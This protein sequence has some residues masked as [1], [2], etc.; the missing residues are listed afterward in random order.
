M[1]TTIADIAKKVGVTGATVSLVLNKNSRISPKTAERVL[2]AA[3]ELEYKPSASARALARRKTENIG[4]LHYTTLQSLSANP[5]YSKIFDG[6]Q[7]ELQKEE[8]NL[9]FASLE[10]NSKKELLLPKILVLLQKV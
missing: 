5:F 9:L 10:Y 2:E 8:Y 4:F 7:K 3:K 6:L 1:R